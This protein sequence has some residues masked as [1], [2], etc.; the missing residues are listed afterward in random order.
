MTVSEY[1]DALWIRYVPRVE[2]QLQPLLIF[3]GTASRDAVRDALFHTLRNET[4]KSLP[5][6]VEMEKRRV[7]PRV[8]GEGRAVSNE[9]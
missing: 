8:G 4:R 3:E 9:P 6:S 5:C 2:V 1:E 7:V